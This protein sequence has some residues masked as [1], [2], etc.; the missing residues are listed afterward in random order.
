[1]GEVLETRRRKTKDR[2]EQLQKELRS[3]EKRVAGKACVYATGSFGRN[4]ASLYSDLDLFIVGLGKNNSRELPPLEEICLKADLILATRALGIPEF[5]GGGEYLVHYT[6]QELIDALG[7][8]DDDAS[9]TFTARLLLLLESRPVL[10][11]EVYDR[12]IDSVVAAYWRDY[13]NHKRD[14]IPTFLANDILRLWR[15]FCVNYEAS[16]SPEPAR[17]KAKRKLKNYKLRHSRLLTCYSALLYLL[18]T[19]VTQ[20]TVHPED[21]VSM[22]R[23]SPTER[24]DWLVAN[25]DLTDEARK[26]VSQLLEHYERFLQATDHPKSDLIDTFLDPEQGREHFRLAGKLGDLTCEALKIVGQDSAFNRVL[27]V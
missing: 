18:A 11:S 23:L 19:F 20:R 10:G 7:K 5:S 13:K 4:E 16:T 21:A 15:T 26:T 25:K 2:F 14:F 9:N 1:M 27:V 22:A 24:L 17:E 6:Q 12:I 8:R 3:A